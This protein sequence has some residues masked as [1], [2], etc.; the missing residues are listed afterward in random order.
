MI[1]TIEKGK[2]E[3]RKEL[4][5]TF[6]K[7][8]AYQSNQFDTKDIKLIEELFTQQQIELL[9]A[10]KVY[11]EENKKKIEVVDIE[12]IKVSDLI[13]HIDSIIKEI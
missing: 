4:W 9:K 2:E 8:R 11:V 12:Y 5:D 1:N 6:Y 3:F 7:N 10:V 13:K